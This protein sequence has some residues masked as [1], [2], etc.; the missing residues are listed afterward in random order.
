[1]CSHC[2]NW[3]LS[4]AIA[5]LTPL[6]SAS[7]PAVRVLRVA[8]DPNNLPFS[9]ERGEGFENKLVEL[10]AREMGATIEYTW[11]AQRRGFFRNNFKEGNC[12]LVAG[13]PARF[14][15][16]LT[17][18]PYYRSTY[19]LVSRADRGLAIRSLDD[20]ALREL[21][22]GV[23]MVGDDFANT[24]PAHALAHRGIVANV[25]GFTLYGDY[26]EPSPPSRIITAVVTGEVDVA[27]VWGPLAGYF[28][29]SADVP[30]TLTPLPDKDAVSDLAFAFSISVGVRRSDKML[31]DEVNAILVRKRTEIDALLLAYGVPRAQTAP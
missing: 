4:L 7:D 22:I 16:L 13:V 17:S 26:R 20:P 21:T 28:A 31:R 27:I 1:M 9:N 24:P 10:I 19:V 25:R 5:L 2:R 8:A 14:D 6:L 12:D 30:L 18:T 15:P 3:V 23:Q 11:W 29:K